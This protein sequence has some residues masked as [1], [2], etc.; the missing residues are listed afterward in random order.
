MKKKI[1][2]IG[3]LNMDLVIEMK[4]MPLVGE[5]VAG[6]SLAYI[7]GGKGANQA[8]AAAR[9][10]GAVTML[11]CVGSDQM[12]DAL[13]ESL[14]ESG[15]EISQ[16]RR[17]ADTPT[18]MAM[19]YVNQEG[20]NSIV[21]LSGANACCDISYLQEKDTLFAEADYVMLQMEIPRE[22]VFYAAR[23]AK[24]LGKTVILNPAP[25]PS[26]KDLPA[27]LWAQIDYLTP[28]ETELAALCGEES[29]CGQEQVLKGAAK[30]LAKGVGNV[31]VTLGEK[32]ALLINRQGEAFFPARAVAAAD[33]T[34]AGD[35]FHGAFV[36]SLAEGKERADAIAFANLASSIA[37]T[38]KGAQ[39][40]I[41]AREEVQ[42]LVREA[43]C[44]PLFGSIKIPSVPEWKC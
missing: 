31:L 21:V 27:D 8:Y 17:S 15:A 19:I 42:E 11:G 24:E 1:L 44:T 5:T 16:I 32:G 14:K 29:L 30:L 38:R 23:R 3:S 36:V 26:P 39:S 22:A 2:L 35:C 4:R 25:A 33:T 9:L 34:A 13:L 28:N 41:P 6:E 20:N 43:A 18:G 12:G 10:G 37:V 7:P 40:S